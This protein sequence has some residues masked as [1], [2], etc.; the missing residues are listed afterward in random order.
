MLVCGYDGHTTPAPRPFEKI[1]QSYQR[2]KGDGEGYS[3]LKNITANNRDGGREYS[4]CVQI[5][6]K[7]GN[8]WSTAGQAGN[9]AAG[10]SGD[11]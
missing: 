8:P 10:R 2:L 1:I 4:V 3:P 7:L 11:P 5:V 6:M 9:P